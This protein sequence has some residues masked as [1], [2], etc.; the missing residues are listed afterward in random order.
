MAWSGSLPDLLTNHV[1]TAQ[2]Y[3]RL[4]Q[5]QEN[6]VRW[7]RQVWPALTAQPTDRKD[8]SP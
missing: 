5:H 2:A 4:A 1:E 8:R 3:H 6:L 7:L